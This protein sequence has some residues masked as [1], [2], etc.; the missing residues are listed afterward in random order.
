MQPEDKHS[1]NSLQEL[2]RDGFAIDENHPGAKHNL[3][4]LQQDSFTE[5]LD[6]WRAGDT[7]PEEAEQRLNDLKNQVVL[8][9]PLDHTHPGLRNITPR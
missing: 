4:P 5:L 1:L 9:K 6:R 7:L 8:G 3:T 2:L